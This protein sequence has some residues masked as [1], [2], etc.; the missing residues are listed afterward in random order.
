M[1]FEPVKDQFSPQ[2]P[3]RTQRNIKIQ[4]VILFLMFLQPM[5]RHK[6]KVIEIDDAVAV[7]VAGDNG[8]ADRLA[9]I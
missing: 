1:F 4:K 2:R 9:K 3:Q 7:D 8:F 6:S 5:I